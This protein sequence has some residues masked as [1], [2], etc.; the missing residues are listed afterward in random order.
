V[1]DPDVAFAAPVVTRRRRVQRSKGLLGC[2]VIK[3]Y[4]LIFWQEQ[5]KRTQP[6]QA[7][8]DHFGGAG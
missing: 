2:T 3:P 4:G 1:W 8:W 6:H 5:P 7:I